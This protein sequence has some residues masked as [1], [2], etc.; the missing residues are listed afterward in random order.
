L[1]IK[2][3]KEERKRVRKAKEHMETENQKTRIQEKISN[4]FV[5]PGD[6]LAT[7]EEFEPG[8]GSTVYGDNVV[9]TLVGEVLPDMRNR[10]MNVRP[11]KHEPA[12][13]PEVGD[14]VIGTVQS[15]ASSIA[16]VR[17]DAINEMRSSKDF[18]GMLSLR[19]DRHRRNASPIR[20]GD[21][22]RA[23]VSST[24]NAIYHLSIDDAKCGVLYTVCSF[25]GNRVVALGRGSVKCTECGRTDERLLSEDF[26]A[27]SRSQR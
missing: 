1:I 16:Q 2:K 27:Y 13:L 17:I 11:I 7:Q 15:A 23:K 3:K 21:V 19:D 9:A 6:A 4:R 10:V 14:Y 12:R 25:C 5:L 20:A 24:T 18:T 8:S 22:I 26:I